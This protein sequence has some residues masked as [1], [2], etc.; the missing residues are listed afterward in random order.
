MI[1][2]IVGPL[3]SG[4]RRDQNRLLRSNGNNWLTTLLFDGLQANFVND[5]HHRW[6]ARGDAEL[7][8]G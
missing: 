4:M 1:S 6:I 7:E 2:V 5:R 8:R 3:R